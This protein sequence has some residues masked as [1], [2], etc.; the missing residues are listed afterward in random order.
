MA[1]RNKL[2][3]IGPTIRELRMKRGWT[4]DYLAKKLRALGWKIHGST[5]AEM[6]CTELRIT[7]CDLV[8]LAAALDA[9][10]SDFFPADVTVGTL[11]DKIQSHRLIHNHST[12]QSPPEAQTV[13]KNGHS[14]FFGIFRRFAFWNSRH[15]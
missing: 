2:N 5:L 15:V 9:N 14:N 11:P 13:V 10:F 6:E 3:L 4:Q 7:D 12:V 8:F 1:V